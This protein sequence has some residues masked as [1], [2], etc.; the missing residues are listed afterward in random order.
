MLRLAQGAGKPMP[1]QARVLG[2]AVGSSTSDTE[3]LTDWRVYQPVNIT[4]PR[5]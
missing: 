2:T 5:Y 1:P 4:A 3:I